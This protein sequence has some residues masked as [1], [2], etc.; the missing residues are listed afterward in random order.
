MLEATMLPENIE[1]LA[2]DIEDSEKSIALLN[3]VGISKLFKLMLSLYVY[4]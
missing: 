2:E 4:T 1:E 3:D